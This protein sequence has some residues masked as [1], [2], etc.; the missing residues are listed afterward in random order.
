VPAN[1]LLQLDTAT[2]L[3]AGRSGWELLL[4]LA[5]GFVLFRVLENS[6]K[7]REGRTPPR[8]TGSA[9]TPRA[10]AAEQED[11][12]VAWWFTSGR[13]DGHGDDLDDLDDLDGPDRH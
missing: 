11:D 8:A 9:P 7:R 4:I 13:Y 5:A 2:L 6:K 10:S 3:A 1:D 12:A